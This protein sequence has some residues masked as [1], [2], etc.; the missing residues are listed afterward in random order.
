SRGRVVGFFWPNTGLRM[1]F[2][3]PPA[4]GRMVRRGDGNPTGRYGS[5][6]R[7]QRLH[8]DPDA[9]GTP[10]T[11][12]AGAGDAAAAGRPYRGADA[13]AGSDRRR[14]GSL[15]RTAARRSPGRRVLWLPARDADDHAVGRA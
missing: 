10:V 1:L 13:A 15:R 3:R 7:E 12:G 9:A 11:G 2:A 4:G 14:R 5:G 6:R 8:A